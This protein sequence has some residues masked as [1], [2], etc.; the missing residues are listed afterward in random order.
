MQANWES[1]QFNFEVTTQLNS[2]FLIAIVAT[3]FSQLNEYFSRD[4]EN[5][6]VLMVYIV[7]WC[8]F[9]DKSVGF[10]FKNTLN[11]WIFNLIFT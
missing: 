10:L 9:F 3:D 4:Q 7:G 6:L 2:T 1:V 8:R 11:R 5:I